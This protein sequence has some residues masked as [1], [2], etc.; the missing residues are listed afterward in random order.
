MSVTVIITASPVVSH[1]RMTMI[2]NVVNSLSFAKWEGK[3]A[4]KSCPIIL[5]HDGV[6]PPDQ[7][8]GNIEER[9]CIRL[10]N[11]W[12]YQQYL[13]SLS[14][15]AESQDNVEVV[16]RP[17]YGNLIGNVRHAMEFVKTDYVM[18]CQH[19][20]PFVRRFNLSSIVEDMQKHEILK[21]VRFNK[22]SNSVYID[23]FDGKDKAMF[24]TVYTT[25]KNEYTYTCAW[26][27]TNHITATSY[28]RDVILPECGE[29][30]SYMELI[31]NPKSTAETHD[32]YGT[33]IY[34]NTKNPPMI[35]HLQ[36][37]LK[38]EQ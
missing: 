6:M 28:Y 7:I 11:D 31:I 2:R 16:V 27:E 30:K 8:L 1:P 9:K 15:W 37:R 23:R 4:H 22:R 38:A 3:G 17:E 25:E 33:F 34:G 19:D 14:H 29:A 5:A 18:I 32:K 20:L 24:G 36:G 26:S 35:R 21:H 13:K 12:N 10:E